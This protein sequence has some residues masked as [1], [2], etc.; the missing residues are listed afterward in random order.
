[1]NTLVIKAPGYGDNKK[2][3]LED[4]CAITGATL[5]TEETGTRVE[6]A[7]LDQCGRARRVV[8]H[9]NRTIIIDGKS[10]KKK[11]KEQ[12]ATIKNTLKDVTSTYAKSNLDKRLAKLQ[13]G[14][15]I[16]KVGDLTEEASREKQFRIEDAVN[17]TKSAIEEGVVEGGGM[18]LYRASFRLDELMNTIKD[19]SYRFGLQV[20]KKAIQRPAKQILENEGRNAEVVLS[21]DRGLSKDVIDPFKVERVALQQSVS[22][23]GLFL[24]TNAVVFDKPEEKKNVPIK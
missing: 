9:K 2:L 20:L 17:A 18:A 16:I 5:I 21:G 8:A 4:I 23:V 22:V 7:T 15:A 11:I 10:N 12:I 14:V 1:M 3:H 13:D 24:I 6:E 19:Q